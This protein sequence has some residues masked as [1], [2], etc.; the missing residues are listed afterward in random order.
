[1]RIVSFHFGLS[2]AALLLM[3]LSAGCESPSTEI[4]RSETADAPLDELVFPDGQHHDLGD[5]L[6][7]ENITCSFRI[8]NPSNETIRFRK[9]VST[10]C[11]CTAG[12]L[13]SD[14]LLPGQT[15]KL[16][17]TLSL[18][19]VAG[20][21]KRYSATVHRVLDDEKISNIQFTVDARTKAVW[22][23]VPNQLN[24]RIIDSKLAHIEF[25][26]LGS[27]DSQATI[28]GVST[29]LPGTEFSFD[30][31]ELDSLEPIRVTGNVLGNVPEGK[32]QIVIQSDD[33]KLPERQISIEVRHDSSCDVVPRSL[34]L[35]KPDNSSYFTG[36]ITVIAV[37]PAENLSWDDRD[38]LLC[39]ITSQVTS[40][41]RTVS[42]MEV[43]YN[44]ESEQFREGALTLKLALPD[45]GVKKWEI[46]VRLAR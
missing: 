1:M 41:N 33:V 36:R 26:V 22:Y 21:S 27:I 10:T 37:K 7:N 11:G 5:G 40:G 43:S 31:P 29:T 34:L 2:R 18:P 45:D 44:G 15:T 3:I 12:Q 39:T 42:V 20:E 30:R 23:T 32:Y 17:M 9:A 38:D 46:P 16:K 13:S 35:R 8:Q 14:S 24:C 28:T 4:G 19:P 25:G 6:E